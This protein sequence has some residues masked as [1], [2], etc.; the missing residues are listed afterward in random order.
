MCHRRRRR[1][2]VFR[3]RV[4]GGARAE[5]NNVAR[6]GAQSAG[7]ANINVQIPINFGDAQSFNRSRGNSVSN[8]L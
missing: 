1:R 5:V 6:T 8:L 3:R 7:V 4:V 2:R